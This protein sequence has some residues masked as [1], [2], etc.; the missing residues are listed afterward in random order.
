MQGGRARKFGSVATLAVTIAIACP[1]QAP[2][3][4]VRCGDVITTDTTLDSDLLGCTGGGLRILASGVTLDLG[5]HRVEG[6]HVEFGVSANASRVTVRNGA[7]G[8]F[9]S[10]VALASGSD[11]VVSDVT[12]YDSHDGLRMADVDRVLVDH[13][14]A[15]GNDGSG[16]TFAVSRGVTMSNSF[17]HDNAGGF[18]GVGLESSAIV[19]NRIE[20]NTFYGIRWATVTATLFDGNVVRDNGEFGIGLEEGSTGNRVTRNRVSGTDGEGIALAEDSGANTLDRN[21]SD[22][23]TGRGFAILGAGATLIRNTARRNGALGFEA[24]AGAALAVANKAHHNG[25]RRQCVGIPCR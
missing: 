24:P 22:Y 15:R 20:R 25:D 1:A 19:G 23:N 2:A 12:V 16:I 14:T 11:L 4:H 8:H 9:Q 21:R 5:G 6:S 17:V 3:T 18:G 7:V 13:V 10:A